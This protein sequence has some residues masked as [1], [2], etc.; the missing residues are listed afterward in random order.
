MLKRGLFFFVVAMSL[1]ACR[2]S[3]VNQIK[4]FYLFV[5]TDQQ[6]IKNS[7]EI[8]IQAYNE[9]LGFE[10]LT[11]SERMQDSN[12]VIHFRKGLIKDGKKLGL[13]KWLMTKSINTSGL[14]DKTDTTT[15]DFG[16]D[17]IFDLENFNK[18]IEAIDDM[19]SEEYKHLFH[20]F[21]H[22][23]GH[24]M[25]MDHSADISSVMY[26]SIPDVQKKAPNFDQYFTYIRAFLGRS[27]DL[28]KNQSLQ[29]WDSRMVSER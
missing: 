21:C 17:I 12:S 3:R 16:M 22:E 5:E 10:A 7:V 18:K 13:G 9:K 25:Q 8:L 23:I 20:L 1:F 15:I 24:G 2:E 4:S 6:N 11:V 19:N 26:P 14:L 28:K 27:K 29:H